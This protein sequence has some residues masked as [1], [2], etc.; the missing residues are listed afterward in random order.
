MGHEVNSMRKLRMS[1]CH[2][3]DEGRQQPW[4]RGWAEPQK[5]KEA[6]RLKMNETAAFG[7]GGAN[8][9]GTTQPQARHGGAK[10][11]TTRNCEGISDDVVTGDGSRQRQAATQGRRRTAKE[12]AGVMNE[13]L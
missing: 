3:R 13:D 10:A 12:P 4:R 9:A 2:T 11:G 5:R 6:E 1:K 8:S 7:H